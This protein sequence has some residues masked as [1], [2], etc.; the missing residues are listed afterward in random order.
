VFGGL[1]VAGYLGHL[2]YEVFEDSL[3]FP[4]ALTLI[5][6]VIVWLGILWQRH[7]QR[8]SERLRSLLPAPL[9]ELIERRH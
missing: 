8:V 3:L 4:I 5:G 9:R 6:L 2:A 7:E 1:G